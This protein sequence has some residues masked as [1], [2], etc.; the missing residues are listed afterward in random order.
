MPKK[1]F[2]LAKEL[3]L[4][5]IELVE[6][7]KAEG[8]NVR[9]HMA[10]IDDADLEKVMLLFKSVEKETTTKKKASKKKVAKKKTTK[11]KV[12][13]KISISLSG[14]KEVNKD[15]KATEETTDAAPKKT[16][17]RRKTVVRKKVVEPVVDPTNDNVDMAPA[18]GTLESE[19]SIETIK[20]KPL[21][22]SSLAQ[23]IFKD[24]ET[25]TKTTSNDESKSESEATKTEEVT[26][27]SSAK[28]AGS[29]GLRIVSMP[30]PN[31]VKEK[32]TSSTNSSAGG[33]STT[34][35]SD[36]SKDSKDKKRFGGLASM[37]SGKK[38]NKSQALNQTRA[39]TE[40]KS[41]A[42]LSGA[43]KPIYSQ[44]K[45]KKIYMGLAGSTKITEV[46]ESKRVIKIHDG[47]TVLE[48]AKKLRVK[49]KELVNNCLDLNLL[50]KAEDY[51]G[52]KLA[53]QIAS[54]YD[55]RIENIKFNEDDVIGTSKV[56][57]KDA[58]PRDPVIAIMGHV[59]HGKTTL[60]DYIRETKV[61]DGEAGGITQHIGAYKVKVGEKSLT[62]LDTPGHAAFGSMRQRGAN[63]TD[64][65][66]LVVAADD[67]VMPQ[68]KESIKYIEQAGVPMIIAINKMDKPDVNPDRVKNELTEF[69]I[70]PE[71]WGG[72][73]MMIPI[74]ALKGDGVD[75][76]LESI[77][78][79]SEVLE[80]KANSNKKAEGIVIESK[81]ETGRGPVAT[82]LIQNGNLKKGDNIVVGESYGR[83]RSLIDHL[84]KDQKSA[85]PS[86]PIQILGLSEAPS[87]GDV[88]NVV[89][90][91]REGKKIA[92]NRHSERLLLESTPKVK[93]MSLEDFFATAPVSEEDE[94]KTLNLIVR[95]DVQGSFEAI[96]QSLEPLSNREVEVKIIGGGVG[97]ISDSD[98]QLA[99]AASAIV[100]GF[101][102]RPMTTARKMSESLGV[103]VKTYSIIYELINDVKLAIEGML[104][105]DRIEKFIGR[106]EVKDIFTVPKL[107]T[108]AG[109]VVIDGSLKVGCHIRLLRGGKILHD[110]ELSSLK[111]FKDDVKEVKSGYECGAGLKDYIDIKPE[112]LF[113][114]YIYEEIKK[115]IDDVLKEEK[116]LADQAAQQANL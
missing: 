92:E 87:P 23:S 10:S 2:E 44:V 76:L 15:L 43:G 34:D 105:P 116:K 16:T 60:L 56:E 37:M 114:A 48:L 100:V 29:G 78:V 89:K 97:P 93:K 26:S 70:T 47:A 3:D 54:I 27:S 19:S 25:E 88:L 49:L 82:I 35:D 31:A 42:A 63:L 11:K 58:V 95:S 9:N 64:I 96:K 20:T 22:T 84:G 108:V 36:A 102:M 106:A 38:V 83:A 101:N 40:L 73:T 1:V 85:G 50:L 71:E 68:T 66:I 81:I 107:G 62:F 67:G 55:Y 99:D 79:L 24:D 17:I 13:S 113:E 41:Y 75:Q 45:R 98:I 111:R 12:V 109:L 53:E 74:S 18:E 52:I 61:T 46:K 94:L 51:L 69:N 7:L 65:V 110:G 104:T 21:E 5:A 59:D 72:D 112:D 4:G 91:E 14:K 8:F 115:T 77:A 103:D 86:T 28:K 39:D 90:N 80:L 30:D 6:K 33:S 32:S 57:D